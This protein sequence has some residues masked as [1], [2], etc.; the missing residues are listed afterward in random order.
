MTAALRGG[1]H[2][3]HREAAGLREVAGVVGELAPGAAAPAVAVTVIMPV[4]NAADTLER[5]V[6]SVFAQTLREVE[7][8]ACDD[9]SQ[10]SSL[11]LLRA[12]ADSD[13]RL[14][15]LRTDRNGGPA[16]ARNRALAAATGVWVAVLDADDWY[17]PDRLDQLAR[18]GAETGADFVVDNQVMY[19]AGADRVIGVG[20]PPGDRFTPVRLDDLLLNSL[21]GRARYDYGLLQPM[22]RRAF[23]AANRI[24]YVENVRFGEDFLLALD[25]LAAGARRCSA[26]G[27]CTTSPSHSA[28]GRAR[29]RGP[30]AKPTISAP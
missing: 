11:D 25:C 20:L 17:A 21:T 28:G 16:G 9:C 5:A 22:I 13:S 29:C 15:I 4:Y 3:P 14:R 26:S 23:L 24:R 8:I 18:L 30:T 2:Q 7:I 12:L 6:R 19:D 1:E 10:D 27:R